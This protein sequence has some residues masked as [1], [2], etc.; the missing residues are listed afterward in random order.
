MSLYP[1]KV[2]KRKNGS[3]I[4]VHRLLMEEHLGRKLLTYEHVHHINGNPRD[5]RIESKISKYYLV[6]NMQNYILNSGRIMA[7]GVKLER[8]N[9]K[10][11]SNMVKMLRLLS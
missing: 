5:N 9:S 6:Q 8:K 1:Y 10:S 11:K 4:G 2:K 3:T 7:N